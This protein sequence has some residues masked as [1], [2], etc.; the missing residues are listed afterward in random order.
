M[1]FTEVIKVAIEALKTNKTR[2]GLTMLGIIIGVTSVILLISIGSGLKTYITQQL[3]GLGSN[4]IWV[5]PGELNINAGGGGEGVPGAGVAASKFTF[6]HIKQL[7]GES[8]TIK[9][10][11]AYTENNGTMR[12]KGKSLIT[13]IAGVGPD[14]QEI[15][16]QKVVD[17]AFFTRSQYN[18][19]KK[20]AVLGKTVAEDLFGQEDP[21]GKKITISDQ[22]YTVL[23]ILE[24][25]GA[26]GG[27]DMDKQVFIPA[28]TAM[29]QF[30]MEY[31]QSLW[32]Q[33]RDSESV[34]QTKE[35]IETILLKTLN[36]EEFS[37]LDTKSVLGVV[38]SIL[39]VLTAALSG[40][41]AI[42]LVVGGIGIMNIMLVSVTER[43]REIGLR[44]AIGATPKNI[45]TQ[46]I[47]EAI[48]LSFVGGSVGILLGVGGALLVGRFFTTTITPWSI[49][50][51]FF[52]SSFVGVVFGAAPAYKA[53]KLNPIDALRYE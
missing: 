53:S 50:L 23:G 6:D 4:A 29:H 20:V 43:T 13:Q 15:R 3:E 5:F 46:F 18:S 32:V 26:L 8:K 12:Y 52:V 31:I 41:A 11:M 49:G 34:P 44:K 25:K 22:R 16:D 7:E 14:Y 39:G 45:L 19:A 33:S 51:A 42:S 28:T 36:D 27:I 24:E 1:D 30:D 48:V 21:I 47:V 37:V 40:I 38:S 2:S 9:A 17:G 10:V 35:E